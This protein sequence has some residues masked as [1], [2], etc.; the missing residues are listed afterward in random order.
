METP[1]VETSYTIVVSEKPMPSLGALV[2]VTINDILVF[3]QFVQP[4][5]D[6]MEEKVHQALYTSM[7]YLV[8]YEEIQRSLQG[9]DLSGTGIY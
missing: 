1:Q 3:Q 9:D 5:Y 8:N 2:S 4:R 7:E 6:I